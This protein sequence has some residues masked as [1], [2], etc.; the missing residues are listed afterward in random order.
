MAV[1]LGELLDRDVAMDRQTA[2]I[3]AKTFQV[4]A[5]QPRIVHR[6]V[7]NRHKTW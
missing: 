6:A 1:V 3:V 7:F 2:A 4:E 5:P